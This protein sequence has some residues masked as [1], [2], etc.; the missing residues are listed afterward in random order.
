VVAL[1]RNQ[2]IREQVQVGE[3]VGERFAMNVDRIEMDLE[4]TI[5]MMKEHEKC[6]SCYSVG[7]CK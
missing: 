7:E 1:A 6:S 3:D 4:K 5:L 2:I